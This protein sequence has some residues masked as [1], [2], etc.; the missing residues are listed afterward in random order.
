MTTPTLTVEQ[1][2]ALAAA[3]NGKPASTSST[4]HGHAIVVADRGHVWVGDVVTDGEWANIKG[5]RI[6][7]LWGTTK[8]LNQLANEGPLSGTKLDDRADVR[9]NIKAVIAVIPT[10]ARWS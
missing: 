9:V 4:D 2:F 1:A 5:A 7:R 10:K 3:L 8:G 6:I